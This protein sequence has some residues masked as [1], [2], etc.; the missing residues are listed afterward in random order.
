MFLIGRFLLKNP[1]IQGRR[2]TL[3][4][5]D[6]FCAR[7][8]P[9]GCASTA[10]SFSVTPPPTPTPTTLLHPPSTPYS[11]LPTP[12]P[13]SIPHPCILSQPRIKCLKHSQEALY[14]QGIP[15]H[16]HPCLVLSSEFLQIPQP[17]SSHNTVFVSVSQN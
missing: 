16:P 3:V 7:V 15:P 5:G 4:F 13:P 9:H 2:P 8:E 1:I 14:R 11:L 6:K 10:S 12:T 17:T